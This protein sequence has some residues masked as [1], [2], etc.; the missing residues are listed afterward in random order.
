NSQEVRLA[1]WD[2]RDQSFK[3]SVNVNEL[4]AANGGTDPADFQP[5]FDRVNLAV[6]A[7]NRVLVTYTVKPDGVAMQQ[8]AARGLGFDETTGKFSYL[9]QSFFPFINH[10]PGNIGSYTP[11]PSMTTKELLI[12]AK[13]RPNTMNMPDQGSDL[14][15]DENF[16]TVISHP[17]PKD[18][19][20]SPP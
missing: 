5:A 7:L 16:Y 1:V 2:A 3:G 6:D 12:A 19:P 10:D 17:V 13:G 4:T 11:S 8:V 9:T 14:D 18:D 15:G 20:T